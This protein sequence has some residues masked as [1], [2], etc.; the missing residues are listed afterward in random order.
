MS[1]VEGTMDLCFQGSFDHS[2]KNTSVY[3]HKFV[4]YTEQPRKQP[5]VHLYIYRMLLKIISTC[6]FTSQHGH[7]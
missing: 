5:V 2:L 4:A 7:P 3:Y 1:L 6:P